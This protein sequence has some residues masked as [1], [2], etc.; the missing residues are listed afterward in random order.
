[1]LILTPVFAVYMGASALS[2]VSS[3]PWTAAMVRVTLLLPPPLADAPL[4]PP[5][6]AAST[7]ALAANTARAFIRCINEILLLC[8]SRHSWVPSR[9][10]ARNHLGRHLLL[11][12]RVDL[13]NPD[14]SSFPERARGCFRNPH[15]LQPIARGA[16]ALPA[17]RRA[18]HES[19]R[20]EIGDGGVAEESARGRDVGLWGRLVVAG[21]HSHLVEPPKRAARHPTLRFA[22]SRVEA[23][24]ET[25]LKSDSGRVDLLDQALGLPEIE[26]E[27][28]LAEDGDAAWQRPAD[29]IR[30]R[31]GGCG[32][33]HR[34]RSGDRLVHV[35]GLGTDRGGYLRGATPVRVSQCEAVDERVRHQHPGVQ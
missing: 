21:N 35:R 34:V 9:S 3:T 22:V 18:L 15:G 24:M 31:I 17:A 10:S 19:N 20:I 26:C 33:H 1:M 5:L 8:Y 32:D 14:R 27:R 11:P 12:A 7:T 30:V 23:T 2:P 6:H 29:E 28:L 4:L 16:P 13:R 25:E